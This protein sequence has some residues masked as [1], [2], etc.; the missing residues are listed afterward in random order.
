MGS[1]TPGQVVPGYIRKQAEKVMG[2]KPVSSVCPWPLLDFQSRL[3]WRMNYKLKLEKNKTKQ[4]NPFLPKMILA[5]VFYHSNRQ[6]VAPGQVSREGRW[7][8][9]KSGL[10]ESVS[11]WSSAGCSVG[12]WEMVMPRARAGGGGGACLVSKG[13]LRVHQSLIRA[14]SY[15]GL[16]TILCFAGTTDTGQLGQQNL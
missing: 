16:R 5:M 4:N 2:N 12:A 8:H 13:A 3:H 10:E 15:F 14:N 7:R 6:K 9:W 11:A 1:A